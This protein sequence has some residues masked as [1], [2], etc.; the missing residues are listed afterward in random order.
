LDGVQHASA[1]VEKQVVEMTLNSDAK[2]VMK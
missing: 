1:L 2:E